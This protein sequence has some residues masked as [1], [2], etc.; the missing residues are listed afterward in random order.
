MVKLGKISIW[1]GLLSC[2]FLPPVGAVGQARIFGKIV[3]EKDRPVPG[4]RITVTRPDLTTFRLEEKSDEK[5][6]YAVSLVDAT[7]VHVYRIEKEGFQPLELTL[8][9]PIGSNEKR[10]FRILSLEAARDASG[11]EPS[12]AQRAVGIFNEGVEALQQGDDLVAGQKFEEAVKLDPNL[13]PGWSALAALALQQKQTDRAIELAEKARGLD[14]KEARALRVLVDAYEKAGEKEKSA[15]AKAELVAVDPR[16]AAVEA[17]NEGV[18]QYNAGNMDSA[19]TL[20]EQAVA[21]NPDHAK[22]HYMLGLCLASKGRNPE[23]RQH[24]ETFLRLAPQDPDA[25]TAREMLN[26]LK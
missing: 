10:D 26:Y 15:A 7:K 11:S 22:S 12:P 20:F 1:A 17:F 21:A 19:L 2:L 8:K 16:S 9:I 13:A 5:G 24:F 23:A 25:A 4:A 6:N 14:P 3:D 18:R